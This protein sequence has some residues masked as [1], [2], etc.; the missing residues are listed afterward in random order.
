VHLWVYCDATGEGAPLA[1]EVDAVEPECSS[2]EHDWQTPHH[3][4]GGLRENPGVW[5]NGGGVCCSYVCRHC[6][7]YRHTDTWADDGHGGRYTSTSYDEADDDS[8][9]WV[10]AM[11]RAEVLG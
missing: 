7:M 1:V 6:G 8:L 5:G 3:V 9:A 4:L 10:A 2:D 11:L